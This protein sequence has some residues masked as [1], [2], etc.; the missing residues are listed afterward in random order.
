MKTLVILSGGLDS[1]TCLAHHYSLGDE[2][3]AITFDYGQRH[4]KEIESAVAVAKHYRISHQIR[5]IPISRWVCSALLGDSEIPEGHYSDES[6]RATVVPYRNLIMLSVAAA[7]ATQLHC[8]QVSYGAHSGD[9]AI[10]PD[11]RPAFVTAMD[12]ALYAGDYAK[13]R[14]VA[15]L[16]GMNKRQVAEYA[17]SLNAPIGLT[18]SCYVGGP[19]P[20]GRCGSCVARAEALA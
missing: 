1:T 4:V 15:P 13:V 6:M 7:I 2:C 11:C 10:Y 9:A 20:C 8:E 18:W 12:H 19:Q 3:S 17:K 16:I 14:L 5:P